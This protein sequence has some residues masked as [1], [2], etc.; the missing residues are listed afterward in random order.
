MFHLRK[1]FILKNQC[2]LP[3]VYKSLILPVKFLNKYLL[4]QYGITYY[5]ASREVPPD[6]PELTFTPKTPNVI[7]SNQFHLKLH[8]IWKRSFQL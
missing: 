5:L 6:N 4:D 8:Q 7:S 1:K 3:R 2:I